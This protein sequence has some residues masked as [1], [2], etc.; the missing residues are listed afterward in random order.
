MLNDST[1]KCLVLKVAR[2]L[3]GIQRVS[4]EIEA[5]LSATVTGQLFTELTVTGQLFTELS[6]DIFLQN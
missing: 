1:R 4:V 5:R 6:Q 2:I 3:Q